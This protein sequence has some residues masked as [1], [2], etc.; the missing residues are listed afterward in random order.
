MLSVGWQGAQGARVC[1]TPA[2]V[3]QLSREVSAIDR[4]CKMHLAADDDVSLLALKLSS[5]QKISL[6][7]NSH[8]AA[9]C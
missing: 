3:K 2:E 6:S 4:K 8:V 1:L 7:I 5:V 9:K